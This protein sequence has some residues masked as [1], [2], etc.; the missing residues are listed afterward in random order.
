MLYSIFKTA[1]A[2]DFDL[3]KVISDKVLSKKVKPP[4]ACLSYKQANYI[5]KL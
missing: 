1:N 2:E 5:N 4:R 3:I